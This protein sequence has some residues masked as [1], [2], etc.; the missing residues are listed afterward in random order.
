MTNKEFRE[1]CQY[2]WGRSWKAAASECFD[3]NLRTLRR[4]ATTTAIPASVEEELITVVR[5]V[6]K[7]RIK[8]AKQY[9]K[10]S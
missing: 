3:V 5:V 8:T 1:A 7:H 6:A 4:W 9:V 2:I 10:G